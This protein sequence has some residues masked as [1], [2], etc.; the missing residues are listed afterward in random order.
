VGQAPDLL[1]RQRERLVGVAGQ[2]VAHERGLLGRGADHRLLQLHL[3]QASLRAEL[4]DVALDLHGHARDQLRALQHRE[5]VMKGRAALELQRRQARGDLIQA[6]AEL[7]Q[8]RQRLV[9]LGQHHRNV[10]EDVLAA[11]HIDRDDLAALG[12]RYDQ[13]VRLL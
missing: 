11:V 3:D 12:D 1:Q 2:E 6:G 13:R 5:D 7:V 9:G 10:L 8:R 4:D